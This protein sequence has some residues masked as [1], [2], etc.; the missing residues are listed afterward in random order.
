MK[1]SIIPSLLILV[2]ACACTQVK[3]G[4]ENLEKNKQLAVTYHDLDPANIDVLFTEDFIGHGENGH[5][6]DRESHRRYLSNGKYKVDSINRQVAEGDWVATMF[7]RTME[8]QGD[9]I[10][11]PVMHFKRFKDG[12][13]AEVWEY[14]DFTP[15][16]E[17]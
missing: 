2:L 15:E 17:E 1:K 13:I 11:V 14:Y 7:T 10:T 16:P 4:D 6:W 5:T 12:K 3:T 8:Y 9:T